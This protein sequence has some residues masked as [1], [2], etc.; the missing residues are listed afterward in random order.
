M[1]VKSL[2][3]KGYI[4]SRKSEV[5]PLFYFVFIMVIFFDQ[6]FSYSR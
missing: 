6:F 2:K 5:I 1:S 4:M 3:D